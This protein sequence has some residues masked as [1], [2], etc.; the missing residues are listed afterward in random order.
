VAQRCVRVS[1][2]QLGAGSSSE[3]RELGTPVTRSPRRGH[4]DYYELGSSAALVVVLIV[5]EARR[6]ACLLNDASLLRTPSCWPDG[7]VQ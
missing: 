7:Q 3:V 2:V 6:N 1:C 4:N 5:S